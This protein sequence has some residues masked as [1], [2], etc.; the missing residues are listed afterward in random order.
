MGALD[1]KCLFLSCADR[2]CLIVLHR[3]K[4]SDGG[5]SRAG[6]GAGTPA[7]SSSREVKREP[8]G[9][10]LDSPTSCCLQVPLDGETGLPSCAELKAMLEA[11]KGEEDKAAQPVDPRRS[12][13]GKLLRIQL[14]SEADTSHRSFNWVDAADSEETSNILRPPK[15]NYRRPNESPSAKGLNRLTWD[16]KEESVS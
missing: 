13:S 2:P 16:A 5:R 15:A 10:Q 12:P 14:P 9:Y 1:S 11:E 4:G 3:A 7:D 8:C 6:T